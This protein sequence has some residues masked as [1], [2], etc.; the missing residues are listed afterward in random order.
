MKFNAVVRSSG[1]RLRTEAPI[2][3]GLSVRMSPSNRYYTNPAPTVSDPLGAAGV[4]L[5]ESS[6]DEIDDVLIPSAVPF[7]TVMGTATRL[8]P[9]VSLPSAIQ[10]TRG[11]GEYLCIPYRDR[12][13]T[14][15]FEL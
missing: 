12:Q 2:G 9:H 6:G 3:S 14:T 8:L 4:L 7:S 15:N 10:G 5:G 13:L 11:P 1:T